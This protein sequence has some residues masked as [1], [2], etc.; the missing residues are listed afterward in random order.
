[1]EKTMAEPG[2]LRVAEGVYRVPLSIV[3]AYFLGDP[4]R[5]GAAWA[6]VDAGLSLSAAFIERQAATLFGA[7][8]RPQCILLTHGHFDHVGSLRFLAEK[9]NVPVFAHRLE[10]P[11]LT[12]KADYPPPDPTVG[13]GMA[14]LSPLYSR[15]AIDLGTRVLPLP[16]LGVVPAISGWRWIETPGHSPGHVSFF[17]DSDRTLIAGDAF[18][19]TR[20]ESAYGALA[21]P[22]AIHGPPAYFTIDWVAAAASVRKLAQLRPEVAATGHGVP[23]SGDRM[24]KQLNAL[25][26]HFEEAAVPVGGRYAR[27]PARYDNNG[28]T[29]IPPSVPH[30]LQRVLTGMGIA[31]VAGY[32]IA[33]KTRSIMDE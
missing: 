25:A 11:Y 19:T 28:T 1:L 17:R 12:G 20:Q 24:R 18:V 15:K 6:L 5:P 31:A 7:D 3:N 2:N 10:L 30:S 22:L 13:G 33:R 27:Q 26:E 14:L 16:P 21:K 8:S 29:F 4:S 9:W 32:M 23:M